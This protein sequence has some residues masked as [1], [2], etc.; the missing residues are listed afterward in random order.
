MPDE[1]DALRHFRDETPGPSTDAWNRA[2][3]AIATARA[4]EEPAG[5][6]HRWVPGRRPHRGGRRRMLMITAGGAVLAAI[7]GLFA[8]LLPSTPVTR[9]TG[10]QIETTAF[11]TRVEH[12]LSVSGQRNVVGYA[13]TVYPPGTIVE[14]IRP[15]VVRVSRGQAAN[16]PWAVGYVVRWSYQ[17]TM[18]DSAFT[19]AGHRVFDL[20]FAPV[21]GTLTVTGVSYRNRTWWR[22]GLGPDSAPSAPARCGPDIQIGSGGWP[23]FLR[24]ALSCGEFT[25]GGRQSIGGTGAVELIGNG[26][27]EIFWVNPRTY[28]P[29]RAIFTASSGEQDRTDFAWFAPAKARLAQLRLPVPPGFRQVPAP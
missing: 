5:R 17:G 11:V 27:Q 2:R 3:A 24:H 16:S 28:L 1:L 8:V 12:A 4:E 14:P 7:A 19:A 29:V 22:R 21:H 10:A 23:A 6:G 25:K 20:R 26:G 9:G 18:K 15:G 13:R